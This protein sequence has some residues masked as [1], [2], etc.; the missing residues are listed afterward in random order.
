MIPEQS[1]KIKTVIE[2]QMVIE[3]VDVKLRRSFGPN[4]AN[5]F[6]PFL[7]FDH[8]AFND[9]REGPIQ[10]SEA[11]LCLGSYAP[12]HDRAFFQGVIDE[13][14]LYDRALTA[15]EIAARYRATP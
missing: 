13:V 7:L 3:G 10:P 11:K 1:R 12:G 9:P 14:R 8:F 5:H 2:P 6:D 15:E 4:R